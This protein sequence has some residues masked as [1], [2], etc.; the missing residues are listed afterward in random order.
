MPECKVICVPN[1][2]FM[3]HLFL[4]VIHKGFTFIIL[5]GVLQPAMH[6]YYN[7]LICCILFPYAFEL[8][9]SLFHALPI[10]KLYFFIVHKW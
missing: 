3:L 9:L 10:V 1:F 7:P 4:S 5:S 8:L 6:I 2:F